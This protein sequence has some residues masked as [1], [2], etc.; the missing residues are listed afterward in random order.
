MAE[1]TQSGKVYLKLKNG[2]LY[3]DQGN[4]INISGPEVIEVDESVVNSSRTILRAI[5]TQRIT[6]VEKSEFDAWK[7]LEEKS[8]EESKKNT[9]NTAPESGIMA[10]SQAKPLGEPE[11]PANI[12]QTPVNFDNDDDEDDEEEDEEEDDEDEPSKSEMI[13]AL[14]ASK[15]YKGPKNQLTSLSDSDLKEAYNKYG[16]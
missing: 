6:K 4:Q 5:Q 15:T 1:T 11:S 2:N 12:D 9:F 3:V 10:F 14:K 13:D 8:L 16:K 7:K